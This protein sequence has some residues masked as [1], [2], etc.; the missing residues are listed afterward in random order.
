MHVPSPQKR[1]HKMKDC[2]GL[3]KE[4]QDKKKDDDNNGGAKGRRPPED[5]NNAF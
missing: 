5:N 4:F 2:L 3:A 1:K